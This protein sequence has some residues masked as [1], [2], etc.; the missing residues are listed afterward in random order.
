MQG[1]K[2]N[3]FV[4]LKLKKQRFHHITNL[5]THNT[6]HIFP[7]HLPQDNDLTKP[8]NGHLNILCQP[9]VFFFCCFFFFLKISG[10][11]YKL[12]HIGVLVYVSTTSLTLVLRD[13]NI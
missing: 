4:K 5:S 7:G 3:I 10:S 8:E 1:K 11:L 2:E 9:E 13:A 6:D 12:M